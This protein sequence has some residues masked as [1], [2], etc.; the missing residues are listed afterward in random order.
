MKQ[1]T[2]V[3][4]NKLEFKV[5]TS[6]LDR[7]LS[8]SIRYWKILLIIERNK[9]MKR[10]FLK[11]HKINYKDH[12]KI[13]IVQWEAN[14]LKKNYIELEKSVSTLKKRKKFSLVGIEGIYQRLDQAQT[15]IENADL[16][17]IKLKGINKWN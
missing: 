14:S 2:L 15:D 17:I 4:V 12:T 1:T 10:A 3:T 5:I 8:V 6:R 13:I 9:Q 16:T 7:M 11:L